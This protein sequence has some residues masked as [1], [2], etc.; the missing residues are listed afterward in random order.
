MKNQIPILRKLRRD[1]T[2]NKGTQIIT[3]K[4]KM[5]NEE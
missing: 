5:K 3:K 2:V 4:N 1:K